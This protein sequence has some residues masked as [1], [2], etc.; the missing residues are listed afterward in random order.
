MCGA[1]VEIL[2]ERIAPGDAAAARLF[3][4]ADNRAPALWLSDGETRTCDRLET[5]PA[6]WAGAFARISEPAPRLVVLG[7]DPTAL[8][9]AAL[10]VQAGWQTTLV[11]PKG[12]TEPPPLA[13]VGY[14]RDEPAEALA[15][16][17]LDPWTAVAVASHDAELDRDALIVA[18][19]SAA[20]YVGA[21]GARRRAPERR[22]QLV[23]AGLAAATI[24]RLSSPIGVEIGGKAPWEIAVSALAEMTTVRSAASAALEAAWR[25][26][27]AAGPALAAAG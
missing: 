21:L 8:A 7:G 6:P 24:D 1:R 9:I 20:F 2:L 26:R 25:A 4:L 13:G 23:D 22:M 11:R 19:P 16:I 3:A 10:G 27:I 12:P 5:A 18:L 17:G 15:A 14:S